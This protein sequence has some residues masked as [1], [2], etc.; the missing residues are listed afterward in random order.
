MA[1]TS[2]QALAGMVVVWCLSAPAQDKRLAPELERIQKDYAAQYQQVVEPVK[3]R[4]AEALGA[5]VRKATQLGDLDTAVQARKELEKLERGASSPVPTPAIASGEFIGQWE[6]EE[7]GRTYRRI[8]RP[9]GAV[10]LWRNGRNW[11]ND[12]GQPWWTGFTWRLSDNELEIV[13][14]GGEVLARWRRIA[15]DRVRQTSADG[16]T[17]SEL[18][19]APDEWK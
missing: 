4:H 19:R 7:G 18:K 15:P 6:Y 2:R 16:R 13:K 8:I 3:R 10:E 17:V 9:A 14:P 11:V 1:R 5:L 12:N